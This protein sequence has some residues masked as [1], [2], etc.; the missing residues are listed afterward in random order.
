MHVEP[1]SH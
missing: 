1:C